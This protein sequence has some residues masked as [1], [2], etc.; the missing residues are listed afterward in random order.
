M[1]FPLKKNGWFDYKYFI[2]TPGAANSGWEEVP[3]SDR[4]TL[5]GQFIEFATLETEIYSAQ[6]Q[7]LFSDKMEIQGTFS[8]QID[9][10]RFPPGLY[11]LSLT[12]KAA[13]GVLNRKSSILICK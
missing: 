7:R 10:S 11:Y 1:L 3:T 4:V 12:C 2:T 13:S 8:K 5:E 6:G 9:V